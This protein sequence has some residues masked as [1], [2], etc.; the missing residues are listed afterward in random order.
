MA[1]HGAWW[2]S[3]D[4]VNARSRGHRGW[5][6]R[7]LAGGIPGGDGWRA[8]GMLDAGKE[9][10]AGGG[11]IAGRKTAWAGAGLQEGRRRGA[12]G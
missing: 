3:I 9:D 5:R 2:P 10:G 8:S 4:G 11:G 6:V 12:G 7:G 1:G